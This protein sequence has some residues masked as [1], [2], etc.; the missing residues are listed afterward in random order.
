VARVTWSE[1]AVLDLED[2]HRF[3]ARDSLSAADVT[4]E[5]IRESAV[6]LSRFPEMGRRLPEDPNGDVKE[7]IVPPYRVTYAI[8]RDEVR[9]LTVLHGARRFPA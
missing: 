5:R 8:D 3:I 9:I 1:Q 7:V 6:N 2:I 4:V